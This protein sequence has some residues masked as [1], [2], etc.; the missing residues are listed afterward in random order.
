MR[1][2]VTVSARAV[3][4]AAAEAGRVLGPLVR[5]WCRWAGGP[6]LRWVF[7]TAVL[8][9]FA[10]GPL[11]APRAGLALAI[12]GALP[13]VVAAVAWRY[14]P[15][16]WDKRAAGPWRRYR[17]RHWARRSWPTLAR[18]CGLS[19]SHKVTRRT[20]GWDP[21]DKGGLV[22]AS[23][24]MVTEWTHP[25]LVNATTSGETLCLL[26]QARVGQTREDL[27]AALPAIATAAGAVTS[28]AAMLSPSTVE[29]VLCMRDPLAGVRT[30]VPTGAMTVAASASAASPG[31]GGPVVVGRVEDGTDLH[32]DLTGQAWHLAIQG[33][34]RSGKSALCYTL[35]SGYAARPDV[36]VCGL[37]PSGILLSPWRAGRG[38]GWVATGTADLPA[39]A[40]AAEA[41]VAAMD[42]RIGHLERV[43][44][45][46]IEH[47]DAHCPVILV[48]LE[49]YPGLLASAR[50][51]DDATGR[52]KTQRVAP[53]IERAVGRLVKEGAKVGIRVLLLAQRMSANA[54]DTDDRSNLGTRAT[55]RVDNRDAVRMLHDGADAGLIEDVRQ[56]PPGVGLIES[57]GRPLARWRA[58]YTTYAEY[59]ARVAD[60]IAAIDTHHPGAYRAPTLYPAAAPTDEASTVDVGPV[61]LTRATR[62]PRPARKPRAP[63]RPRVDATGSGA[64]TTGGDAA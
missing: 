21:K 64:D 63:R 45:D 40:E 3:A 26:V 6:G 53:R 58:D 16:W 13:G 62:S 44:L 14:C 29:L 51:D 54:V 1:P 11:G 10:A 2:A 18:E 34:T 42:T 24:R 8:A 57:P 61:P 25:R 38:S 22:A 52:E 27:T 49:E 23:S 43:G 39:H 7:W 28:R 35:L 12:T 36:L 37:D 9:V 30:S 60:G 59:R 33:A 50:A 55:L 15:T 17:W 56:F 31:M 46:K 5:G 47:H 20:V 41:I 4:S 32:V 19:T 48:V